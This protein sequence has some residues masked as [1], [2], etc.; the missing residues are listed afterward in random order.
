VNVNTCRGPTSFWKTPH[1]VHRGNI[2]SLLMMIVSWLY[3]FLKC[4]LMCCGRFVAYGHPGAGHCVWLV[5]S[6]LMVYVMGSAISVGVASLFLL[7]ALGRG[8]VT[9]F[10]HRQSS[11]HFLVCWCAGR[12]CDRTSVSQRGHTTFAFM[13]STKEVPSPVVL[14]RRLF[15]PS[16]DIAFVFAVFICRPTLSKPSV[17]ISSSCCSWVGFPPISIEY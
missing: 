1:F 8:T 13:Q 5:L 7:S 10:L 15:C 9:S 14:G 17:K 12:Y 11:K 3:M 2:P 4:C 16:I 6:T